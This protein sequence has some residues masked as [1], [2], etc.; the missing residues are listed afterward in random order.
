MHTHPRMHT[1]RTHTAK[2]G[3]RARHSLAPTATEFTERHRVPHR[4]VEV[5]V[6]LQ[7]SI[8]PGGVQC[9]RRQGCGSHFRALDDAAFTQQQVQCFGQLPSHRTP[10]RPNRQDRTHC[11]D[12]DTNHHCSRASIGHGERREGCES[13]PGRN[14]LTA[15]TQPRQRRTR[16]ISLIRSAIV[17]RANASSFLERRA[18]ASCT[19]PHDIA[20]DAWTSDGRDDS[21]PRASGVQQCSAASRWSANGKIVRECA[22]K[23]ANARR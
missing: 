20:T 18:F 13:A 2:R 7:S 21:A 17:L 8:S 23:G 16:N 22:G 4:F 10:R 11:R 19:T 14:G 6:A 1:R 15:R 5:H 12:Y 3:W 9:T